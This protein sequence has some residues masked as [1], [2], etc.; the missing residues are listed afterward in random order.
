MSDFLTAVEEHGWTVF[1][2]VVAIVAIVSAAR[3]K[4]IL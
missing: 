1:W 4:D 2:L 3:G